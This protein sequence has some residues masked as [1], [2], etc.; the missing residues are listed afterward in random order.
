MPQL[1]NVPNLERLL[2]R[3]AD[4]LAQELELN[5]ERIVGWGFAQ[6]VLSAWWSLEDHDSGWEPAIACAE[7]LARL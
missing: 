2:A 5:R 3:R 7:I 6:A 1:L 4:Q